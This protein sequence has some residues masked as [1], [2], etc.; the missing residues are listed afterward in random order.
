M[1]VL[2]LIMSFSPYLRSAMVW[3]PLPPAPE[4]TTTTLPQP[5]PLKAPPSPQTRSPP[6]PIPLLKQSLSASQ[7]LPPPPP[8]GVLQ[9]CQ[10]QAHSHP[11]HSGGRPASGDRLPTGMVPLQQSC[12]HMYSKLI[13]I[14]E[15]HCRVIQ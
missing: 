8:S 5:P 12:Q 4:T 9:Q 14:R 11:D 7:P 1:S 2:G 10:G 15:I 3:F 13:H 6:L